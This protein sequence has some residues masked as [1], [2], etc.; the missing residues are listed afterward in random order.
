MPE[1]EGKTNGVSNQQISVVS[2]ATETTTSNY[3]LGEVLSWIKSGKGKFSK[4]VKAVRQAVLDG[5]DATVSDLKRSLPSAMFSGTF[6]RRSAKD[7]DQ[8]SGILCLDFDDLIDAEDT[9]QEVIY[10]PHIVSA[11]ISPSGNGLKILIKIP[12]DDTRH[13]DAFESASAYMSTMYGI[14][15]D[16]SLSLIHI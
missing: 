15:A 3:E 10:D 12:A 2:K 7:L 1:R 8:H 16:E 9:K 5:D 11:F 14:E 13:A 6:H 4:R